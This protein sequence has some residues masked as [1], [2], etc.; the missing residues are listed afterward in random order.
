M[1]DPGYG[2]AKEAERVLKTI[3]KKWSPGEKN[4]KPVSV[5]YALPIQV[6]VK[7]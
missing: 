7:A 6:N 2:L 5:S 3:T 4:G 1:K